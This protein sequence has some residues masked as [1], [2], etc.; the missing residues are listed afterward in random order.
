MIM[1]LLSA[2][3]LFFIQ[4]TFLVGILVAI[5]LSVRRKK[6][7]RKL[8]RV[9][10]N[11]DSHEIKDYFVKGLIPGLIAS[12]LVIAAGIPITIEAI[13]IY[14]LLALL[15]V[16]IGGHFVHPL[17]IMPLTAFLVW[18][19]NKI[20][21]VDQLPNPAKDWYEGFSQTEWINVSLVQNLLIITVV[22][23][24]LTAARFLKQKEK[25]YSPKIVETKR[26]KKIAAYR[27]TP[28]WVIPLILVIPGEAFS[29]LFD[30][31]PVFSIGDS[32]YSFFVLPV[33]SGFKYTVRSYVPR[34]ATAE[35]AKDLFVVAALTTLCLVGSYWAP[36]LTYIATALVFL[37]GIT[38]LMRHAFR[39]K[40]GHQLYAPA[41]GG[42]KVIGIRPGT[43]AEKMNLQIGETV[44]M[45]N[46]TTVE[47]E[48]DFHEA[49]SKNSVYCRLK[50][51]DIKGEPRLTETAL[52]ADDPHGLGIVFLP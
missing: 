32:N 40:K 9:A 5:L 41:N 15:A 38:V 6:Q 3:L 20:E 48:E 23:L 2:L 27:L 51:K 14:Q 13:I 24:F 1:N 43:P 44:V 18:G 29:N 26:G 4:P 22:L 19:S 28:F 34:E 36:V 31:W 8:F 42:L 37:G 35:L 49:L 25:N 39:E 46:E 11:K 7:E 16:I 21:L 47:T 33:L 17:F 30:W 10:I 52:Y 12:I 45:C 50:V